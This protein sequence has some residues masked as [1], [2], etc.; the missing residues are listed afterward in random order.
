MGGTRVILG[1]VGTR[2]RIMRVESEQ[3]VGDL[4][5]TVPGSLLF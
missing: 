3:K 1:G 2:F 5:G 4:K